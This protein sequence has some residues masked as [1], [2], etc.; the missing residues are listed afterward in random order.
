MIP[1]M[2]TRR[3]RFKRSIDRLAVTAPPASAVADD[4]YVGRPDEI[5][6]RLVPLLD[7][8]PASLHALVGGVGSG[9]TTQLLVAAAHLRSVC[10][11]A[12]VYVDVSLRQDLSRI[13][14]GTL[15][16]VLGLALLDMEVIDPVPEV[17][18]DVDWFMKWATGYH[19]DEYPF[20]DDIQPGRWVP[21]VVTPPPR[22]TAE[23][24][25]R[26]SQLAS[27]RKGAD[28]IL[29]ARRAGNPDRL[30]AVSWA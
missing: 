23:M 25:L 10:N 5:S 24:M 26:A 18:K 30:R 12:A 3:D 8:R 7:I 21:G 6:S 14:P 29:H 13:G 19:D 28:L 2:A 17:A 9:K 27:I 15:L 16:A 11:L 20:D 4:I 22:L 1:I